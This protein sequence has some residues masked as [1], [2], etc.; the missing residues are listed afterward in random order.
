MKIQ[1]FFSSPQGDIPLDPAQHALPFKM[2][3]TQEH[4]RLTL[5]SYF[6]ALGQFLLK[7]SGEDLLHLL[8]KELSHTIAFD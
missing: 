4:P 6:D 1:Y 7:A 5:G 8:G 2:T 3:P